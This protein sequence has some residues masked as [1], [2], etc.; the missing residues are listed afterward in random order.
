[1]ALPF[2]AAARTT[3][4]SPR[5]WRALLAMM[6]VGIAAG[7]RPSES[8]AEAAA[9]T[10]GVPAAGRE[11]IGDFGCGTC[12]TIPGV[13]GANSLVGPPLIGMAYRTYIAGVLTNEPANLVRWIQDP[14]AVDSLTAMPDLGVSADQARQ[15][16]AYL[17][18]L[19]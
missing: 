16:A 18:S 6:L 11:L 4:R 8:E 1:M 9:L 19:R 10:G 5:E 17:Y 7:C 15:M 3:T 2:P 13:P 12:H 14:Q